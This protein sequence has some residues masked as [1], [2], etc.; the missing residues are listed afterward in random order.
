VLGASAAH[1]P[2]PTDSSSGS[3]ARPE[4]Y[5]DTVEIGGSNPSRKTHGAFGYWLGPP[6]FTRTQCSNTIRRMKLCTKCD[7]T[8]PLDSFGKKGADRRQAHC[9]ECNRNYQRAHYAANKPVYKAKAAAWRRAARDAAFKELWSYLILHPCVDCGEG[10]PVVLHFDHVRGVK[11]AGIAQMMRA[12]RPWTEI[13]EEIA[14]CEVRCANCHM[15][16]TSRHGAW[17]KHFLRDL[18]AV[19]EVGRAA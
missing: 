16:R 15:R 6:V 11:A 7:R 2:R 3:S 9:K 10:D 12:F 17:R 8:L 14:K 13:L 18:G 19:G 5:L 4:R 1:T